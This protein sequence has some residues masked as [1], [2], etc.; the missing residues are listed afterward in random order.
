MMVTELLLTSNLHKPSW[1]FILGWIIPAN[2]APVL[3]ETFSFV[4]TL[5]VVVLPV[6]RKT[7]RGIE[8]LEGGFRFSLSLYI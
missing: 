7:M 8:A 5:Q 2:M 3:E 4:H 6:M 1:Y